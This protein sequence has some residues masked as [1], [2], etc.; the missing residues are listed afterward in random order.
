M[1]L[2]L[3]TTYGEEKLT[4]SLLSSWPGDP[5]AT[6]RSSHFRSACWL[7]FRIYKSREVLSLSLSKLCLLLY[8]ITVSNSSKPSNYQVHRSKIFLVGV[9][10]LV[11]LEPRKK[12]PVLFW[13]SIWEWF[14]ETLIKVWL[15]LI[16]DILDGLF[17]KPKWAM[18]ETKHL[19]AVITSVILQMNPTME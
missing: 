12:F 7:T 4:V 17:R 1:P 13:I 19:T 5:G 2:H 11:F 10:L 9:F 16:C 8:L 15:R 3:S 6:G 14:E 18:F